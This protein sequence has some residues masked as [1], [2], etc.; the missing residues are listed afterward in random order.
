MT[1]NVTGL[2]WQQSFDHNGDGSIDYND[3][4]SYDNCLEVA[5]SVKTG[6]YTDWRLPTIKEMYSLIQFSGR[7]IAPE[8]ISTAGLTP[9]IDNEVF[10]FAYGKG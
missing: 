5:T 2:M 4:L 1:D 6:G 7:D 10:D 8:A 9:F 3:K